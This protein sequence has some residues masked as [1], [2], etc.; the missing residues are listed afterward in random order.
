MLVFFRMSTVEVIEV[1]VK[2]SKVLLVFLLGFGNQG[3]RCNPFLLCANHNGCAMGIVSANVN[4]LVTTH[5]LEAGPHVRLYVFD[6][7][8]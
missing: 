7:M 2:I 1:D 5:F 6:E 4:T 8:A 3:F